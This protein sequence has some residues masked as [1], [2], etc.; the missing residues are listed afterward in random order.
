[1]AEAKNESNDLLLKVKQ[2]Q[3]D[4]YDRKI[5]EL[6]KDVA[7]CQER[8]KLREAEIVKRD[9]R[10]VERDRR[11]VEMLNLM[12]SIAQRLER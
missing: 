11:D 12:K 6:I 4:G 9:E 2:E 3:I 8:D 1:M 5:T 10:D 7:R